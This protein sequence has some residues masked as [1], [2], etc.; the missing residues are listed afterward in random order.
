VRHRRLTAE[1]RARILE[2]LNAR[3]RYTLK[4]IAA[5]HGVSRWTLWRLAEKQRLQPDVAERRVN[6]Q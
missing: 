6:T 1:Q 5:R 3:K 2:D 4:A